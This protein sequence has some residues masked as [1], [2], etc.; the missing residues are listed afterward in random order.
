M[1]TI[2]KFVKNDLMY[3]DQFNQIEMH[4]F[5][6]YFLNTH[7]HTH[8]GNICFVYIYLKHIYIQTRSFADL[9]EKQK[10]HTNAQMPL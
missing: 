7:T 6:R 5:F 8:N 9:H 10:K 4:V 2:A 1:K 3:T